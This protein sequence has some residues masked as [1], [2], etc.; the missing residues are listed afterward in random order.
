MWVCVISIR[1]ADVGA[2][3]LIGLTRYYGSWRFG[4]VVLQQWQQAM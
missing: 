4:T 2:E 1:Q 3:V